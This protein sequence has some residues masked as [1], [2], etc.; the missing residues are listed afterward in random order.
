M[1]SNL[2]N[3]VYLNNVIE[4]LEYMVSNNKS[5][6]AYLL[7]ILDSS[8]YV[9]CNRNSLKTITT[10]SYTSYRFTII[11]KSTLYTVGQVEC[12][13]SNMIEYIVY[14]IAEKVVYQ[15]SMENDLHI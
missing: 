4:A 5:I 15:C 12:R 7:D 1:S 13:V 6:P 9:Y 2:T 10:D 8:K 3:N 14:D 11:D